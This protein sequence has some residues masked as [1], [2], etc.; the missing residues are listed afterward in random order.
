MYKA[1]H[2]IHVKIS[3]VTLHRLVL[4]QNDDDVPNLIV[5]L[6]IE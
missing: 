6:T 5:L 2:F 4:T 3:V 1:L